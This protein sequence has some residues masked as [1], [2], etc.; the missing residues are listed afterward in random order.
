MQIKLQHI[1]NFKLLFNFI[2]PNI[3]SILKKRVIY[4]ELTSHQKIFIQ[5]AGCVIITPGCIFGY[6]I[7]GRFKNGYVELQSRYKN[8]E[9]VIGKKVA[10]N[11]N[12]FICAA[13]YIEIGDETRIGEGVTIMDFE[14]TWYFALRKGGPGPV[15]KVNIGKNVWIG[16]KVIILKNSIIGDNTIIAAGAVVSGSFPPN[17]IIGGVPAK[18]IKQIEG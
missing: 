3:K 18:L 10:T 16:N 9:I 4:K 11:N 14:S 8:A 17:S 2:I 15:G 13:N 1:T 12:L 7:G 5:G 6:P